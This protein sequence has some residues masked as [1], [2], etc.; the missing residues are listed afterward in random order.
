MIMLSMYI[1]G[2]VWVLHFEKYT[3]I[4]AI[5]STAL[6]KYTKPDHAKHFMY[7]TGVIEDIAGAMH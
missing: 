3:A 6:P 7:P 2:P 1:P 4:P 5:I